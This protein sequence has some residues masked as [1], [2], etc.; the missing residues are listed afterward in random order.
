MLRTV[1]NIVVS[2]SITVIATGSVGFICW[3]RS[4]DL[5]TFRTAEILERME[6]DNA[7]MKADYN[8]MQDDIKLFTGLVIKNGENLKEHSRMLESH[9]RQIEGLNQIK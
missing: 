4:I 7:E 3:M 5:N 9:Q 2:V 1:K 6:A 8:E